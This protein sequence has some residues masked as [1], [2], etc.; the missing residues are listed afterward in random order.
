MIIGVVFVIFGFIFKKFKLFFLLAGF[1]DLSKEEVEKYDLNK[2]W[3]F[4]S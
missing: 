3:I 4:C 1:N 2:Y